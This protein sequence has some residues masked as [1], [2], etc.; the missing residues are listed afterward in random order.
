MKKFLALF[1]ALLMLA[2]SV[3]LLSACKKEKEDDDKS[4]IKDTYGIA[5]ADPEDLCDALEDA[6]YTTHYRT[7]SNN[8]GMTAQLYASNEEHAVYIIYCEAEKTAQLYYNVVKAEYDNDIACL[9]AEIELCQHMV[10]DYADDLTSSE[11]DDYEDEVK[12]MKQ[13]LKEFQEDYVLGYSGTVVW[14][15]NRSAFEHINSSNKK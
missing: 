8:P 3:T 12:E 4:S 10:Q 1:F 15:G 14:Y 5:T 7:D 13:E 6:N 9:E 11:L 2:S